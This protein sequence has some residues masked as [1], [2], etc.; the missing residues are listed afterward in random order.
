MQLVGDIV[1]APT[2]EELAHAIQKL[3]PFY[4]KWD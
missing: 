4:G 1:P 2:I 3:N